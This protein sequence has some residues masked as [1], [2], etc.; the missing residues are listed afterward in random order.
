[1][2]L[3]RLAEAAMVPIRIPKGILILMTFICALLSLV[4]TCKPRTNGTCR[5]FFPS[6]EYYFDN[7]IYHHRKSISKTLDVIGGGR[8][9]GW[10]T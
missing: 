7:R 6:E 5:S 8:R 1:L 2:H 9:F 3:K 4:G 10:S